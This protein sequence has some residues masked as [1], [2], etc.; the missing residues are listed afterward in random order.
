LGVSAEEL[1][2]SDLGYIDIPAT[3]FL[4]IPVEI[5]WKIS[6]RSL[7]CSGNRYCVG[8]RVS[9]KQSMSIDIGRIKA[10]KVNLM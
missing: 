10:S 1:F 4:L 2:Q 9:L 6:V 5:S 3:S 7:L 8:A